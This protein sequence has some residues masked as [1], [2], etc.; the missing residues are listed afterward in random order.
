[1]VTEKQ[2]QRLIRT[3][4]NLE[5]DREIFM[6]RWKEIARQMI[7]SYGTWGATSSMNPKK[8]DDTKDNFDNT[9]NESSNQMADGLM[10]S[11]FG[12]NIAWFSLLFEDD[13]INDNEAAAEWLYDQEKKLYRQFDRS[14]FYD[15]SRS[16]IR[17]GADFG[18]ATM[19]MEEQP[20]E[21]KPFFR[22][23]HPKDV[24]LMENRFGVVDT[25]FRDLYLTKDDAIAEFGEKNIPLTIK[26]SED[27]TKKHL[28]HQYIG[29]NYRF[30]LDVDG[31]DEYISVYWCDEDPTKAVKEERYPRKPFVAWRWNRDLEGSVYGTQ[32]PGMMQISNMKSANV[33][34]KNVIEHSQM[35]A[36][37]PIKKTEGLVINIKPRG[38]TS[39]KPG[40]D[41]APVNVAGDLTFTEREREYI[42]Q[43][44]RQAY[45]SDFFLLL[46]RNVDKTK[47]ATEVA[48]IMNEQSNIMSSFFNRLATEFLEPVIEF[49]FQNEMDHARLDAVP[50]SLSEI[51]EKDIKIDFVSPMFMI[52]KRSHTIDNLMQAV[53]QILGLAQANPELVDKI[54]FDELADAIADGWNVRKLLIKSETDVKKIRDARLQAQAQMMQQQKAQEAVKNL[55]QIYKD[56]SKAPEEGSPMA[57][58]E[59]G[60]AIAA[61]V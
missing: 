22:T 34:E 52:Q 47:T 2:L 61:G 23:L 58:D 31:A 4:Q 46:S 50:N 10:G 43:S 39:L 8:L 15:E 29:A 57:S 25:M 27:Y 56:T 21:G 19:F 30:D 12:R 17:Q 44:I 55:G 28:F 18:T 53:T 13:D 37:P 1:M 11:C 35:I 9:A 51:A 24:V 32:A 48:G 6:S 36:G 41:F 60:A 20:E 40:E 45:Y 49:V 14:N 54:K 16:F 5:T 7:S 38:V 26:D 33:L 3:K 59:L 42:R